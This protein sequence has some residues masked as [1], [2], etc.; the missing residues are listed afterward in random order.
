MAKPQTPLRERLEIRL[1]ENLDGL[2][3]GV[4]LDMYSLVSEVEFVA[5]SV[6]SSN[7]DVRHG[8]LVQRRSTQHCAAFDRSQPRL[9]EKAI[10]ATSIG[11]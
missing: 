1:D 8:G 3:T 4:D 11:L 2:F 9:C 7:D 5:S 10:A 6:P